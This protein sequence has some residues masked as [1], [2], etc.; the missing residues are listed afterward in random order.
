MEQNFAK[1]LVK[2]NEGFLKGYEERGLHVFKGVP[3]AAPPVG[4]L[5]F[6]Q[7]A[8]HGEWR[9]VR[10]AANYA[11]ASIQATHM[12]DI[13]PDAVN[14]QYEEDCLYL[15]IW[16]PAKTSEEKLPVYFWIHGGGLVAG[17]GN[18]PVCDG[19]NLAQKQNI[20]VVTINYRL[21][22]FGF[23]AHPDLRA[24][25]DHASAGNYAFWDMRKAAMWIKRNIAAF[26]GDPDN[27]TIAGQSGGSMAVGALFASPEMKGIARNMVMESGPMY[28]IVMPIKTREEIDEN[29]RSFMNLAGCSTID[30]LRKKD[31]WELYDI[32]LRNKL[33]MNFNY[34]ADGWFLPKPVIDIMDEGSFNDCNLMIGCTSQEFWLTRRDGMPISEYEGYLQKHFPDDW[35]QILEWYP[36]STPQEAGKQLATLGSDFMVVSCAKAGQTLRKYGKNAYV[37]LVKKQ[38]END[39]GR[40]IGSPHCAEMPYIFGTEDKGGSNPFADYKWQPSDYVFEAR[41]MGYWGNYARSGNPNGAGLSVWPVYEND[42]DIMTLDNEC[43]ALPAS[44]YPKYAYLLDKLNKGEHPK[45]VPVFMG[46]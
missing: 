40:L 16:S 46:E 33:V 20:I 2:V 43:E 12:L 34:C 3:Y 32:I 31:A 18:E 6:R 27:I 7:P 1:S 24:E 8:D 23:F 44:E 5:R 41:M 45:M 29:A 22:F 39:E 38:T 37:F 30:E 10:N 28:W 36:A 35:E 9:G 42:F 17:S 26:G 13:F 21:G 25:N 11:A 4:E 19:F 14:G 15:N